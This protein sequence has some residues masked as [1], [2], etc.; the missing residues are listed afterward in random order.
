M[1]YLLC[2]SACISTD[3]TVDEM[4][5]LVRAQLDIA[6]TPSIK[7]VTASNSSCSRYCY[8]AT[9]YACKRFLTG[10]CHLRTISGTHVR[11]EMSIYIEPVS[12]ADASQMRI[13]P[14]QP[15]LEAVWTGL[16]CLSLLPM[17]IPVDLACS[18][19]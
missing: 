2:A 5:V 8:C 18:P 7:I 17:S 6:Q 19:C 14:F 10:V 1:L 16:N 11:V 9:W 4:Q 12:S 13:K 15:G 3:D